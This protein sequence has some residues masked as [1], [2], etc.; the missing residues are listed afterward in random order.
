MKNTR[1]IFFFLMMWGFGL[2]LSA[3]T[4]QLSDIV[5]PGPDAGIQQYYELEVDMDQVR[6]QLKGAPPLGSEQPGRQIQLPTADGQWHTFELWEAP[7]MMDGLAKRFPMIKK[8]QRARY[9]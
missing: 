9:R 5:T 1:G 4:V 8:P 2:G 6:N 3:Q 7:I